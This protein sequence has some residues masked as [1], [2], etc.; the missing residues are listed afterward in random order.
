MACSK[1]QASSLKH[2]SAGLQWNGGGRRLTLGGGLE[3]AH[4][5]SGWWRWMHFAGAVMKSWT[6][7]VAHT[8]LAASL[9]AAKLAMAASHLLLLA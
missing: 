8:S 1:A 7:L 5:Q 4:V 2:K 9:E 6:G 3:A